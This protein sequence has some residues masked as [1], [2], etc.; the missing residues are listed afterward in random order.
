MSGFS[1]NNRAAVFTIGVLILSSMPLCL[2]A[3]AGFEWVPPSEVNEMA[4]LQT[5]TPAMPVLDP[6]EDVSHPMMPLLPPSQGEN[7]SV[8]APAPVVMSEPLSPQRAGEQAGDKKEPIT[9]HRK[10]PPVR[11]RNVQAALKASVLKAASAKSGGGLF[12]NPYPVQDEFSNG[13]GNTLAGPG[14]VEKAMMEES[15]ILNPVPLG[16]GYSTGLKPSASPSSVHKT[17]GGLQPV[18]LLSGEDMSMTSL[19]GDG[20]AAAPFGMAAPMPGQMPDQAQVAPSPV[21]P[22]PVASVPSAPAPESFEQ[23]VGSGRDLPLAL[24]LAQV[25]PPDYA[26]AFGTSVDAGANVSWEGGKPWNEVLDDMLRPLG[27]RADIHSN[28]VMVHGV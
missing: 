20:M 21:S 22:P 23:A 16:M 1:E 11:A 8:P 27:L 3:W 2:P 25:I 7:V 4:P 15:R 9:L 26:L 12:I 24:A 17:D 19:P 6:L 28:R 18:N 5:E 14:L 10:R 13:A